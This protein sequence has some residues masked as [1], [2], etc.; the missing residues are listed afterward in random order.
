MNGDCQPV[1]D[2][3]LVYCGECKHYDS[4][5][6]IFAPDYCDHPMNVTRDYKGDRTYF[7][8]PCDKNH[9]KMCRH[10]ESKE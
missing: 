10:Y 3:A 2:D 7:K 1:G 4:G 8:K 6:L 5:F 9:N